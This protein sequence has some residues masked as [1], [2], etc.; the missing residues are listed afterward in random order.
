MYT[1]WMI[2]TDKI[3]KKQKHMARSSCVYVLGMQALL[4]PSRVFNINTQSTCRRA[5]KP[6]Q[7]KE[8]RWTWR[9]EQERADSLSCVTTYWCLSYLCENYAWKARQCVSEFIF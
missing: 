5:L 7:D 2:H 6:L 3:F 9:Y 8:D 4:T 1:P